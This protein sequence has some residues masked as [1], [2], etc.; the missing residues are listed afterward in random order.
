MK[1]EVSEKY[2]QTVSADLEEENLCGAIIHFYVNQYLK[3]END[4]Q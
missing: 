1:K 4:N 2:A 3:Y